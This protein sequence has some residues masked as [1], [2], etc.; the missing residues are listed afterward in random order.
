MPQ[1]LRDDVQSDP[2]RDKITGI[3]VSQPMKDEIAWQA[4]KCHRPSEERSMLLLPNFAFF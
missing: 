2:R 3:G 1:L 4:C